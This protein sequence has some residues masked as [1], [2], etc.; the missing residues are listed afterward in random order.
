MT[1]L[2]KVAADGLD[3]DNPDTHQA[4]QSVLDDH[5]LDHVKD[6]Q[7]RVWKILGKLN[8]KS[9]PLNNAGPGPQRINF[10]SVV[11]FGIDQRVPTEYASAVAA[12]DDAAAEA[13]K[14]AAILEK[15]QIEARLNLAPL[16]ERAPIPTP[17]AKTPEFEGKTAG[18]TERAHAVLSASG[19]SRWLNCPPSALLEDAADD[20]TGAAAEEGTAAHAL[21]EHKLRRALKQRSDRPTSPYE[22]DAMGDYTDEYVTYVLAKYEEAK[23]LSADAEIL[24]EQRL[25][26]S[27]L[28]PGGFGTGDC[29]IVADGRMTVIDFKYGAGVLVDAWGNPQMRL[30]AL[31]ALA[32][33]DMLYDITEVEM[34]IYQPRRENISEWSQTTDQLTEWGETVVKPAA[35]LAAAGEGEMKAGAWCTFCKLKNTCRAR[36]KAN[37]EIA[38]WEFEEPTELS[39]NEIAEALALIPQ[40]KTWMN[41]LEK[42]ANTL[43]IEKGKQWPGFKL[44]AGRSIRK[45]T[46]PDAVAAAAEAAGYSDI[47]DRK[48]IGITAMEKLMGK[49]TFTDVLGA[50]VHK[51]EGK[52]TLVPESDRRPAVKGRSAA[53]DFG[54]E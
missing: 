45:Y 38:Q 54:T 30:Y 33:F 9:V 37:L 5:N 28:V 48:L 15:E 27:H 53:D 22:D 11:S 49:Q 4:L 3:F 8:K 25:D 26:F 20:E 40:A 52:P 14:R 31:G 23:Q 6:K 13:A 42:Y 43:A 36:A 19:A 46:D 32:E 1:Y 50:L 17:P 35:E 16:Q 34:V 21:A 10:S 44:V 18:Q 12:G 41:D 51:P 24:I 47:F 7:G 2:P 29:V 39:D